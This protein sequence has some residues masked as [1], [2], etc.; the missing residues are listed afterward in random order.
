MNPLPGGVKLETSRDF[1]LES[2]TLRFLGSSPHGVPAP[3]LFFLSPLAP[4]PYR[5][6]VQTLKPQDVC[7]LSQV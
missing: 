6:A 7:L 5:L 3:S 1:R 2:G 4:S